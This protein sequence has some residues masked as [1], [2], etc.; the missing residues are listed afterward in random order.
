MLVRIIFVECRD[1][2][3]KSGNFLEV[4]VFSWRICST[5]ER[6]SVLLD[7]SKTC[8]KR[9][10][11]SQHIFFSHLWFSVWFRHVYIIEMTMVSELQSLTWRKKIS[12]KSSTWPSFVWFLCQENV[13]SRRSFY[14]KWCFYLVII[15]MEERVHSLRTLNAKET[16][17]KQWWYNIFCNQ[18][19]KHKDWNYTLEVI[20]CRNG[21]SSKS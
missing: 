6:A 21:C 15:Q 4:D 13:V 2:F 20:V 3:S 5:K 7:F 8:N 18:I 16:N 9:F 17:L 19:G 11:N 12:G 1:S 14:L 10:E